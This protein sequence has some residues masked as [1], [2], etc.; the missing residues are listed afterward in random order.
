MFNVFVCNSVAYDHQLDAC[1]VIRNFSL[2]GN[3]NINVLSTFA[4]R[5]YKDEPVSC[6]TCLLCLLYRRVLQSLS[7]YSSFG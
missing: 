6:D 2:S 4:K 3:K 1:F 7:A 5:S